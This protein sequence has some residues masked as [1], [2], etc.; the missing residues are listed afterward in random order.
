LLARY[1]DAF[2][3][4]DVDALVSLLRA[5]ATLSM[6]PYPLWLRGRDAWRAWFESGTGAQCTD[7]RLIRV[8]AN[9]RPAFAAYRSTDSDGTYEP[10]AIQVLDLTSDG[11]CAVHAFLD[12]DLFGLFGMPA[13]L[14][15]PPACAE[16]GTS[17]L[18]HRGAA[19]DREA[20]GHASKTTTE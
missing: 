19:G 5:D 20:R 16:P 7:H 9:G 13:V 11:I 10:F 18:R 15:Q 3:R 17:G 2:E 6:P 4:L 1:V 14:L 8:D 12:P